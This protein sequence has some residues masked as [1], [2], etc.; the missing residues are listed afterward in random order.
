MG[1]RDE[2]MQGVPT[3]DGSGRGERSIRVSGQGMYVGCVE[4][5]QFCFCL[6]L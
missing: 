3:G 4:I 1:P 5:C 2:A 6:L